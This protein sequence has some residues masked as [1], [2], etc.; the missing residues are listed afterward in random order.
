M[1]VPSEHYNEEFWD[2]EI[3]SAVEEPDPVL[4]NLRITRCHYLLSLALRSVLGDEAGANF[5]SWAVW[6]SRK[7]GVTI[8]QEDLD[9][10]RRD[11]TVVGGIVGC[12][13]GIGLGWYLR[14]WLGWPVIPGMG[15]F[16]AVCGALTGRYIIIRSR[17]VSSRLILEGNRTVLEDIGRQS[18]RFIARFHAQQTRDPAALEDFLKELRQGETS[19]GG[20]ELLR[21]AF[22]QYHTAKYGA[23]AKERQEAA[24]LANCLAVLHEHVRLEPYIKGSMPWIVRRCVTKRLLQFDIGPVRLAVAKSVPPLDGIPYP[25]SLRSLSNR[26]LVEFLTGPDGWDFGD[27]ARN[28]HGAQDWT[29]IRERMRYIVNLFRALHLDACV[30]RAPYDPEQMAS[31][32]RGVLPSGSL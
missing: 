10:A 17:R 9:D 11:G 7:A 12:L 15:I 30:F 3:R 21:R 18:A 16:G 29:K 31:V 27:P 26:E 1:S 24:Y 20:Q 25:E 19:A 32:G 28:G 13:V 6:G 5:H 8:R 4:S 22:T 23:T 14:T 2:R